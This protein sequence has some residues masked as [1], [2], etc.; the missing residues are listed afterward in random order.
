[1]VIAH[2]GK[3]ITNGKKNKWDFAGKSS[4]FSRQD[5]VEN[6]RSQVDGSGSDKFNE[7]EVKLILAKCCDG[8]KSSLVL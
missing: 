4:N 2:Q 5:K 7:K 8:E 3:K 1:M 6:S